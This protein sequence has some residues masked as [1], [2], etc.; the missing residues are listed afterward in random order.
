METEKPKF[1]D[2]KNDMAF[3]KIFGTAGK[4]E[5]LLSFIN[6]ILKLPED[7][8]ITFLEILNPYQL[9]NVQDAKSIIID[10]KARDKDNKEYIIEMQVADTVA[11]SKRVQYYVA[12]NFADQIVRGESY[13]KLNPVIFIGILDFNY[14]ASPN[15]LSKHKT[16]DLETYESYLNEIEY[17]FVEL[18]KF[19]KTADELTD[20]AD[21]WL[22]F[23]KNAEYLKNLPATV[24][25]VGLQN[26]YTD[27]GF[28]SWTKEE[29]AAYD[30]MFMIQADI[31]GRAEMAIIKAE[32][33][34][35]E[36]GIEQGSKKN[37][38]EIAKKLLKKGF[39]NEDISEV[40]GLS[41][42]EI[43]KIRQENQL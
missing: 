41:A 17:Y 31:K 40:T 13:A 19:N 24:K 2:V 16:V 37:S 3:H 28:F 29:L 12:K 27:A 25:D 38:I 8:K 33:K 42:T 7:K 32:E 39:S 4:T 9:P 1:V 20:L 26:A 6:A 35:I 11:F 43:E 18:P 36:K 21:E 30:Y 15:Y 34:G 14:K 5:A 10:I 22:Y 23:I